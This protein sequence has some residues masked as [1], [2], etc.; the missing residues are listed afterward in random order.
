MLF[1]KKI[2]NKYKNFLEFHINSI[3][4]GETKSKV[5]KSLIVSQK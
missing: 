3:C 5:N 1:F 2:Y 4:K